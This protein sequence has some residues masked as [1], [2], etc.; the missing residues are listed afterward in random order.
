MTRADVEKM[1]STSNKI[2]NPHLI[3]SEMKSSRVA[4][5]TSGNEI[6]RKRSSQFSLS[7]SLP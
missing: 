7:R 4:L 3:V 6:F 2:D 5:H 1:L